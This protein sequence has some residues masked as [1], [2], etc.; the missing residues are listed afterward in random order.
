[1]SDRTK[2]PKGPYVKITRVWQE[3]VEKELRRIKKDRQWLAAKL[4]VAKGTITNILAEDAASS[5]LVEKINLI[6]DIAPPEYDDD[7]DQEMHQGLQRIKKENPAKYMEYYQEIR[8]FIRAIETRGTTE[9]DGPD[10][11]NS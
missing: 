11:D 4:D 1:M 8:R 2:R 7:I 5:R 10:G 3:R 6:L 9:D